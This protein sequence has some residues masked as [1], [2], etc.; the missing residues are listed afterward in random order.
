MKVAL[1]GNQIVGEVD[2]KEPLRN[3]KEKNIEK[4]KKWAKDIIAKISAVKI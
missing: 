3:N 1:K 2:F 4:A